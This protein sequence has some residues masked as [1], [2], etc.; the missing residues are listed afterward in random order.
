MPRD[1]L[2]TVREAFVSTIGQTVP[3]GDA[4]MSVA[5]QRYTE[6]TVDRSGLVNIP[7]VGTEEYE[8]ET[9]A[10]FVT[11]SDWTQ[12]LDELTSRISVR[13]PITVAE[14]MGVALGHAT[15][16]Y[17]MR[18]D[19]FG[20]QGDFTT[21]PE[22]SQMYGELIGV[23]CVY[24]WEMMGK[25]EAFRLVELGPGRGSLMADLLRGVAQFPDFCRALERG[26]GVH[27]VETSPALRVLQRESLKCTRPDGSSVERAQ[28][29][30][31]HR[32]EDEWD[33]AEKAGELNLIAPLVW[34]GRRN[35]ANSVP[36]SWHRTFEDVVSRG[37]AKVLDS[38]GASGSGAPPLFVIA[39]EFFDALPIHQFEFT[40]RKQ[41]R[42][43]LIDIDPVEA[44]PLPADG[45]IPDV[46][47][48]RHHLRFVLATGETPASKVLLNKSI[49]S[50]KHLMKP[51]TGAEICA[52][53]AAIMQDILRA[54]STCG[55]AALIVDYGG[56]GV[57]ENSLRGIQNHEFVHPLKEPGNVDL[58]A[59]VDFAFLKSVCLNERAVTAKRL[60]KTGLKNDFTVRG[61]V[62]Q[63]DFLRDMQIGA[64]TQCLLEAA[65]SEDEQWAIARAVKRLIDPETFDEEG[66]KLP[67]M[68]IAYKAFAVMAPVPSSLVD[69]G[70]GLGKGPDPDAFVIPGFPMPDQV[71]KGSLPFKIS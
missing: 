42:E 12:V 68:G 69:V 11:K 44:S 50:N 16:G 28:D 61:P 13:G 34:T 27:F 51:G 43:R 60:E 56:N 36:V 35:A 53:G 67:G 10:T 31:E 41:W 7:V 70:D 64:R 47:D 38:E 1:L 2:L 58:S 3:K 29:G 39:Q 5:G 46:V 4:D 54:I 21:A 32:M 22:V 9:D 30:G 15:H 49:K 25:P 40:K 33:R 6:I 55:G 37:T 48:K 59:D 23:W 20:E 18:K 8:K 63:G 57:G 52:S 14:F 66:N 71:G 26:G 65:S 17:Y 45:K 24:N 62:T 19:V